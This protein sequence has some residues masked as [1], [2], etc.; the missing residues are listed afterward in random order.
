MH[1]L[2]SFKSVPPYFWAWCC[3]RPPLCGCVQS[4]GFP[5]TGAAQLAKSKFQNC[6]LSV[7]HVL[8]EQ[9]NEAL[10]GCRDAL[11]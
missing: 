9:N 6:L 5:V 4:Q 2:L 3:S 7:H 11:G 10:Q 8:K 1:I